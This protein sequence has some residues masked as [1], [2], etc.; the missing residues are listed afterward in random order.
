MKSILVILLIF[1]G[2]VAC[3]SNRNGKGDL[4]LE[5]KKELLAEKR[6]AL[7]ELEGEVKQLI[8]DIADEDPSLQEV[9]RL[10]NVQELKQQAFE[11]FITVQ[12]AVTADDVVNVVSEVPGRILSVK[13]KEGDPVQ[14]GQLIATLDLEGINKQIAEINSSLSLAKDVYERQNRLWAQKIGSEVQY[15]QAKNNVERLEKTL[16][17]MEYQKTKSK[18]FAPISGVV[19]AEGLKSGELASPG[20]PI[21]RILNTS[22]LKIVID[23]P[24]RYLIIA[25]KGQNVSLSFPSLNL[26]MTGYISMLGRSIDAANRTLKV[27]ITPRGNTKLLKPNLLAEVKLR[28]VAKNNVLVVPVQF[29]L[30]DVSSQDFVYLAILSPSGAFRVSKQYVSTGEAYEGQIVIES[31]INAGDKLITKGARNVSEGEL[32]QIEETTTTVNE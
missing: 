28:E 7:A 6:A 30:Q 18:V 25:K 19:D 3:D 26:E 2:F 27:E 11:R 1:I 12:G 9:A 13:V 31:G 5:S 20:V 29:V 17:T 14:A 21:I 15:L 8:D 10:V 22:K 32:I 23:L 16:E 24:E 4:D